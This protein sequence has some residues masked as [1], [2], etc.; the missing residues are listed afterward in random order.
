M[1]EKKTTL[2]E[3]AAA[4]G[5]ETKIDVVAGNAKA[6]VEQTTED[7]PEDENPLLLKL[8]VPYTFEGVCYTKLDLTGVENLTAADLIRASDIVERRKNRPTMVLEL[9]MQYLFTCASFATGLPLEFYQKLP[10][11]DAVAVKNAVS[12]S[13]FSE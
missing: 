4:D 3:A 2:P 10:A 5:K 11:K 13:F 7:A 6:L 12:G 8:P 9:D 1:N